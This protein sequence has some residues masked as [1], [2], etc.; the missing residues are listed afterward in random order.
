MERKI[1]TIEDIDVLAEHRV[2]S[3]DGHDIYL[4]GLSS[5][6]NLNTTIF[7]YIKLPYLLDLIYHKRFF[8]PNRKSFTDLRDKIGEEKHIEGKSSP[9]CAVPSYLERQR[10]ARNKKK[11]FSACISCWTM[12]ERKNGTNDENYLMWKAYSSNDIVCRIE[13]NI[14]NII[15]SI[16][17][18]KYDMVISDVDYYSCAQLNDIEKY[19][20][21][22]SIYYE[23][24]QE[25]RFLVFCNKL[26]GIYIDIN[27]QI[28]IKEIVISPFVSL[29][30]QNFVC[31]QLKEFCNSHNLNV[32]IRTS[33][34][35]EYPNDFYITEKAK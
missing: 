35:M 7:R 5:L 20:F 24:E 11:A 31:R 19:I 28:F 21:Q 18:L 17:N 9:F 4:R 25:I 29:L 1:L 3:I 2:K 22:K 34:I 8:I 13:T 10:I 15:D 27:P 33:N 30:M 12:D 16:K 6:I 32:K 23:N 14:Q 26:D